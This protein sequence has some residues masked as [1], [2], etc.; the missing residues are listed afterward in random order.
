ML[1]TGTIFHGERDFV[2][3]FIRYD[4]LFQSKAVAIQFDFEPLGRRI[5]IFFAGNNG[6]ETLAQAIA[7]YNGQRVVLNRERSAVSQP[8][9][10]RIA[11]ED[12]RGHAQCATK[13]EINFTVVVPRAA[14][15]H[16]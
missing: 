4:F 13:A 16:Y 3:R 6:V 15:L 9:E 1:I 10:N 14:W 5:W 12:G 11:R 7:R 8:I 2:E